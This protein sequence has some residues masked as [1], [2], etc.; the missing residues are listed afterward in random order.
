MADTS[1]AV[2]FKNVDKWF[3]DFH[4][5]KNID[6]KVLTGE[7]I[8]ICGPSGSGKSTLVRC[9]NSLEQHNSGSIVV[10]GKEV[11]KNLSRGTE[12]SSEVG[13]VFQ[14]FNLFPH[15]TVNE[16]LILGPMKARGLSRK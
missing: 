6:L 8:V 2:E 9:I 5:L 3:D 4:V 12:V 11:N 13:M 15:L 1:L 7:K 10:H 14:Q 16:N